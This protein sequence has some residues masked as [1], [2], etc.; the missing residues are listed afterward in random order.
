MIELSSVKKVN[1]LYLPFGSET[2]ICPDCCMLVFGIMGVIGPWFMVGV[3]CGWFWLPEEQIIL[4]PINSRRGRYSPYRKSRPSESLETQL[5]FGILSSCLLLSS[6]F[7]L[8]HLEIYLKL[9]PNKY[10]Y[11]SL[12]D[13]WIYTQ[14]FSLIDK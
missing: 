1:W 12:V 14:H 3:G 7:E 10:C 2:I 13:T 8:R 5:K 9:L 4:K 6:L 11:I